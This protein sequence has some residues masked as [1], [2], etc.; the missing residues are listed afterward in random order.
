MEI[1]IYINKLIES[2]FL[3]T[4]VYEFPRNKPDFFIIERQ[5]T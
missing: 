4:K 3:I 2:N 5:S 1:F